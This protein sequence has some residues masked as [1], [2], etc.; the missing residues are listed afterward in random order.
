LESTSSLDQRVGE[1]IR[2]GGITNKNL[3]LR[4]I[5]PTERKTRCKTP[6]KKDFLNFSVLGK[7]LRTGQ[8]GQP[9]EQG[10]KRDGKKNKL[11]TSQRPRGGAGGFTFLRSGKN[12]KKRT[13]KGNA[14]RKQDRKMAG[15][16]NKGGL[17]DQTSFRGGRGE[18]QCVFG[19]A[20]IPRTT[21]GHSE[22]SNWE[23]PISSAKGG[24]EGA[25]GHSPVRGRAHGG[26]TRTIRGPSNF[27]REKTK[28]DGVTNRGRRWKR[29][30]PWGGL[31]TRPNAEQTSGANSLPNEH[32]PRQENPVGKKKIGGRVKKRR[33]DGKRKPRGGG[34]F[35]FFFGGKRGVWGFGGV[36][37]GV[38]GGGG[39]VGGVGGLGGVWGGGG[40]GLGV[41]GGRGG[42]G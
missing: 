4:R 2:Q 33:G 36:G 38:W 42:R 29:T 30:L 10:G 3:N 16:E 28:M 7:E 9:V 41:W 24:G 8:V 26:A 12:Q 32:L 31:G 14:F 20:Q 22:G 18:P 40:G 5:E 39:G 1:R 35:C 34:G 25:R 13:H 15:K 21:N 17:K 37:G 27:G 23:N 6:K 19:Q 11:K